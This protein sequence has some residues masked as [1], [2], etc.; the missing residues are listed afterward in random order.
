M[1]DEKLSG[2]WSSLYAVSGFS[3][4]CGHCGANAGPSLGYKCSYTF[5]N[6]SRTSGNIY[7]CPTCNK[8][9]FFINK[10]MSSSEE[11]FPG[12]MYGN[13]IDFLPEEIL[14]LYNEARNCVSV[15][16]FTA[17]VLSCRKLLMNVAVTKGAQED[18]SFAYYVKFLNENHFIPPGSNEWVDH[19]RNKGNEATHEIPNMG[20]EDAIELLDFTEMLLRVVYEMPGKMSKY[21]VTT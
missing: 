16:A 21:R 18:K 6:S 1:K 10:T 13:N 14:E 7:I 15:N 5:K 20:K 8:P 12:L 3:F 19:I 2:S 9:T 4:V 11:Q 17:S